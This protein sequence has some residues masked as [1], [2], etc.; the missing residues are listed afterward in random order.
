[1]EQRM[2]FELTNNGFADRSLRPNWGT[3][4]FLWQERKELHLCTT[5]L[6]T[7]RLSSLSL[8]SQTKKTIYIVF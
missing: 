6:E 7:E 1:M 8:L 3:S 4:A 2:R 5:V